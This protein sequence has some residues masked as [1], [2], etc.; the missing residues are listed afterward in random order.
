MGKVILV[1]GGTDGIGLSFVRMLRA[2]HA[3]EYGK[4]YVLGRNF[5]QLEVHTADL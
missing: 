3:D 2:E 4:C 5:D 1:A